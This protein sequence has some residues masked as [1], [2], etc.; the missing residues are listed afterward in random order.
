MFRARLELN[1]EYLDL[2]AENLAGLVHFLSVRP[3]STGFFEELARYPFVRVREV[4]ASLD[5]LSDETVRVLAQDK[6]QAVLTALINNDSANGRIPADRIDELIATDDSALLYA[7]F[8]NLQQMK[9]IDAGRVS[10]L[11]A[12]HKDPSMRLEVAGSSNTDMDLLH[13]LARDVSAHGRA[14]GVDVADGRQQFGFEQ[15]ALAAFLQ[16]H[17]ADNQARYCD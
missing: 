3:E 9:E 14:A 5:N 13:D 4:I 7:I 11:L 16:R 15:L 17:W 2:S 12:I 10:H 1:H 6:S 8:A